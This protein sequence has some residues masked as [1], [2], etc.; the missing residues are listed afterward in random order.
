LDIAGKPSET[1]ILNKL[2][3]YLARNRKKDA[4]QEIQEIIDEV[5]EKGIIDESQGDMIEN[6]IILNDT[7][8][9]EIMVPKMDMVTIEV[10]KPVSDVVNAITQSGYSTIPVYQGK[11]DNIIGVVHAKDML[12]H[13]DQCAQGINIA[14]I[15]RKP[16]FVPESKKL[17]DLLKDFKQ[18]KIKVAFVI[19][20][21]GS[22]DGLTTLEDILNEIV[23]TESPETDIQEKGDGVFA[24][25]P[26]MSIDEFRDDFSVDIP[27]GDYDTVAGF[28]ISKLERIPEKGE[29]YDF[30]TMSFEIE[31]ASKKRISKLTVRIHQ[32]KS[33]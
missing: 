24:V 19:D 3:E 4:I 16:Y 27:D 25:D 29:I 22:V 32:E 33:I 2:K 12:I 15:M 20:E 11:I 23:E 21:Y 10:S 9:R 7:M 30:G 28:I 5:E 6:I 1:S 13:M 14:D 17:N 18:R 31:E 26:R 8:V